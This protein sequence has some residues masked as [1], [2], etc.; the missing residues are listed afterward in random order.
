MTLGGGLFGRHRGEAEALPL[1][2]APFLCDAAPAQ[3]GPE[4]AGEALAVLARL[5]YEQTT[6]CPWRDASFR[7]RE[8]SFLAARAI[9]E[10]MEAHHWLEPSLASLPFACAADDPPDAP[11][12]RSRAHPKP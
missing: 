2:D 6:L 9:L 11:A 10:E 3:P 12:R 7:E 1:G 4:A 8:R 5:I